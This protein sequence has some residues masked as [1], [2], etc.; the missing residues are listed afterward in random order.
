M[1][2]VD[3]KLSILV[4]GR[5][6]IGELVKSKLCTG[7]IYFLN[8]NNVCFCEAEYMYLD[9]ANICTNVIDGKVSGC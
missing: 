6:W 2:E 9:Y 3:M 7:N 4:G 5:K 8:E 1:V